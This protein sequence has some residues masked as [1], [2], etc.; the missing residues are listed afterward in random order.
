MNK[1]L[2]LCKEE[3]AFLFII[4]ILEISIFLYFFIKKKTFIF[5]SE[6]SLLNFQQFLTLMGDYGVQIFILSLTI[7][8]ISYHVNNN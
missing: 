7:D 4:C 2:S 1:L 5:H 8:N 3:T 6:A